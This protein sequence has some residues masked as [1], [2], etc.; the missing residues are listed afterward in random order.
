MT[1]VQHVL[2]GLAL[3]GGT[4]FCVSAVIGV[5]RFP[6]LY[7]RL[8]ATT[9]GVTAGSLLLLAGVAILE[10]DFF[11]VGK[12]FIIGLFFLVTNPIATHA[13]ARAACREQL[14]EPQVIVDEYQEYL[15][16]LREEEEGG[17][18]YRSDHW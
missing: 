3:L 10:A 7:T 1:V 12:L 9:K 6:D 16:R 4:F 14:C 18:E 15:D 5:L 11:V 8:H 2:A 13:I 17:L